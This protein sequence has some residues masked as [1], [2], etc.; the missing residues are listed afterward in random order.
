[1]HAWYCICQ[2]RADSL[3]KIEVPGKIEARRKRGWQRVRWLDS[4]TDSIDMSL[5]KLW[6]MVKDREAWWAAVHGVAKGLTLLSNWTTT[7]H[8][9]KKED[10]AGVPEVTTAIAHHLT[11]RPELPHG[12]GPDPA[13]SPPPQKSPRTRKQLSKGQGCCLPPCLGPPTP[14][15]ATAILC[16]TACGLEPTPAKEN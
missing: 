4:I 2:W 11:S 3:E 15:P 13:Q 14:A 7:V 6:E 10:A 8:F 9:F 5:S 16:P 1:M 12:S